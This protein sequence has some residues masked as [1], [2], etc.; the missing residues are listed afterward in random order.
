[1]RSPAMMVAGLVLFAAA[2]ASTSDPTVAVSGGRVQGRALSTAG[3][4]FKGIPFAQPPVGDLRWREPQRVKGWTGVRQA[5]DYGPACPQTDSG[6]NKLA[7]GRSQEDCLYL[8]VWTPE[9]PARTK[10]AVM[11]WIHGGGNNGGSAMGAG[12]IEPPFD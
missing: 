9:W 1:M 5:A 4:A 12:G 11:V 8:N 3:A 10:K 7:A 2:S 6:W